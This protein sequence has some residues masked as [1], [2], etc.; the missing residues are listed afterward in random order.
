[1]IGRGRRCGGGSGHKQLRLRAT[2]STHRSL[3]PSS[4]V[5]PR[6]QQFEASA[7]R[8]PG[9][10]P[11]TKGAT[12]TRG[13]T[14][15]ATRSERY[16]SGSM[17]TDDRKPS[18]NEVARAVRDELEGR[19]LFNEHYEVYVPEV[20]V[21]FGFGMATAHG[22]FTSGSTVGFLEDRSILGEGH[23]GCKPSQRS[24]RP[25]GRPLGRGRWP[26]AARSRRVQNHYRRPVHLE[27]LD[28]EAIRATGRS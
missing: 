21:N 12:G 24:S 5:T 25:P 11:R 18:R 28:E 2:V 3:G 14:G 15:S 7:G 1:M 9:I 4:A 16:T 27:N 19:R 8:I 22:G 20:A 17:P 10:L 23:A 13:P 6:V 26:S